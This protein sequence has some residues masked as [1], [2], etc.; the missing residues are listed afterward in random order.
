MN[1][2]IPSIQKVQEELEKLSLEKS[3][4]QAQRVMFSVIALLDPTV[5]DKDPESV[6][7][8]FTDSDGKIR[9]NAGWFFEDKMIADRKA[10][11]KIHGENALGIDFKAYGVSKASKR[12]VSWA[13]GVTPN[14]EDEAFNGKFNVGIDFVVPKSCE[15]LS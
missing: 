2:P 6:F 7:Q 14:F 1:S 4:S 9:A 15:R 11:Y 3:F 10:V 8:L 5:A 12:I 13:T